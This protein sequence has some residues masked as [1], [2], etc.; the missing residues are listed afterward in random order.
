MS[1]V[2][3]MSSPFF[4]PP[5]LCRKA[6]G[7]GEEEAESLPKIDEAEGVGDFGL[8]LGSAKGLIS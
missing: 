6:V 5:L 3:E 7:E 1:L 4:S 8:M 2:G